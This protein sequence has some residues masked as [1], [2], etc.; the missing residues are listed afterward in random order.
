MSDFIKI[1]NIFLINEYINA[2]NNINIVIVYHIIYD[3]K[4]K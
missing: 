2:I 1:T 4:H 3:N